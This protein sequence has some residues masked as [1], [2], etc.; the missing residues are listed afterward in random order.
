MHAW[1]NSYYQ[2]KPFAAVVIEARQPF[3]LPQTKKAAAY[4]NANGGFPRG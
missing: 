1:Q 2:S 4:V 3:T